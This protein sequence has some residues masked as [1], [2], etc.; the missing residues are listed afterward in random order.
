MKVAINC[1]SF[2]NKDFTGI[3]RY[4]SQ[5]IRTLATID[6]ENQ[7]LLYAPKRF[8]NTRRRIPKIEGHNLTLKID[9]F[10][11]G[12]DRTVGE[13]DVYHSPSP[14]LLTVKC[15]KIIVTIHD[16]IFKAFPQG[17]PPMTISQ[18]QAQLED[19]IA[20]ATKII[21]CSQNTMNDLKRYFNVNG[22]K[23]VLIYQGVERGEFYPIDEEE[24][25][26]ALQMLK[27]KGVHEPYLLFVGTLEPR[28][29]LRNILHAFGLLKQSKA[30]SGKLILIGMMGWMNED[31]RSIVDQLNLRSDV[32][33]MGY[34]TN[35]ELRYFYN[36]A[37][38]FLFPS[39][40]EGFGFPIVEA[41]SC[42]TPVV[43][44]N[45]SSCPE[46]AGDAAVRADPASPESIA[47]AVGQILNAPELKAQLRERGLRRAQ[48]FSFE[49]T[50][51]RT[52]EVYREVFEG[53]NSK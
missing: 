39:F 30:F 29:N 33:F 49:K 8:F 27:T 11:R 31:L 18:T 7:Y 35:Q 52:L 45:V 34:V 24:R 51:Q 42:G 46:V 26:Q 17:H 22:S 40:Y 12:V 4:T 53:A 10:E 25:K 36:Q 14:E 9:R 48:E 37:E 19:T 16:L 5:L 41:F 44:S 38:V 32:L 1:R 23:A 21:C 43:T 13:M 28:K 6:E 50:A 15:P 3:G 2:L 47:Q 20:R